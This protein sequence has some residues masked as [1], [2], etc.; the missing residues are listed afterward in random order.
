MKLFI[1]ND[2]EC[3]CHSKSY[4]ENFFFFALKT[5]SFVQNTLWLLAFMLEEAQ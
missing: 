1:I 4:G 3:D 2:C 5:V